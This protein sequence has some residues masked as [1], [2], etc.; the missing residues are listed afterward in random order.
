[1]ER[2]FH[3]MIFSSN[4][5]KTLSTQPGFLEQLD[6]T[7]NG[8]NESVNIRKKFKSMNFFNHFRKNLNLISVDLKT[9]V[10]SVGE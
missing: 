5:I 10:V 4:V 9:K 7:T 8:A 1:M 6:T 2:V 3:L